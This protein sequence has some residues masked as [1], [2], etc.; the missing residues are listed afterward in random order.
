MI[1]GA[2]ALLVA[3]SLSAYDDRDLKAIGQGR[4]VYL[5]NCAACH[6]ADVKGGAA[7]PDLTAIS[8]RDGAFEPLHVQARI[9]HAAGGAMPAWGRVVTS[10]RGD[11][12]AVRE[13]HLLTR[14]LEYAQTPGVT[15][16]V[17]PSA[18][19]PAAGRPP[20]R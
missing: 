4:G 8:V 11:L 7:T 15:L 19:E 18:D 16:A 1:L 12:A 14:Y 6:G 5:K 9:R 2:S 17:R 20:G 10:R 13:I 3:A